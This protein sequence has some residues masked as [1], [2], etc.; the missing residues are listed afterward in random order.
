MLESQAAICRA[1]AQAQP[2]IR[3]VYFYGSRV[4]GAPRADSDLDVMLIAEAAASMDLDPWT[5]RLTKSLRLN[6]HIANHWD[7]EPQI[8][9]RVRTE[10]ILVL[11]R[12]GEQDFEFDD[13]PIEIDYGFRS[14]STPG[15]AL[16]SI[17]SRK[18]P[19]AVET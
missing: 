11:S 4:W 15:R 19:P 8:M 10:G 14:A 17:H 3:R 7:A 2:A 18:A 12:W 16:P 6:V 5:R 13:H 1:W 9:H